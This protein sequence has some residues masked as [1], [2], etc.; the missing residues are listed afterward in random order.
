MTIKDDA[1]NEP[2]VV[3]PIS[4]DDAAKEARLSEGMAKAFGADDE[5]MDVPGSSEAKVEDAVEP[6]QD[7]PETTLP[8]TPDTPAPDATTLDEMVADIPPQL[9][10]AAMWAKQFHGASPQDL[11][12]FWHKD[13]E[14][15]EKQFT[16]Y[17]QNMNRVNQQMA[18]LGRQQA[19]TR[20]A[21]PDQPMPELKPLTAEDVEENPEALLEQLNLAIHTVNQQ[22]QVLSQQ[23]SAAQQQQ[24]IQTAQEV[25][26]FFESDQMQ[27]FR[28][29]YGEK[30]SLDNP[31]VSRV[32]LEADAIL[33]GANA[34]NRV[35]SPME[36]LQA[37]HDMITAPM[38]Q[39][40]VRQEIKSSLQKR[41]K[42]STFRPSHKSG[43]AGNSEDARQQRLREGMAKAG[44]I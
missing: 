20:A 30:V 32:M 27:P 43:K 26:N 29:Y 6:R 41:A 15:A 23:Q 38:I 22:Q 35:M 33:A 31:N 9:W 16:G 17:Y 25:V 1:T 14:I 19:N 37:A 39:D 7:E 12:E 18:E 2:D 42:G 40:R 10:R 4:T 11:A 24:M 5:P 34:Q 28:D 21:Q 3:K 44:L 13:P 36:A 8:D